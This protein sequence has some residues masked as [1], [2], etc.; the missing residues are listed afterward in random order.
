MYQKSNYKS[1]ISRCDPEKLKQLIN[2][3]PSPKTSGQDSGRI[4]GSSKDADS[5]LH[6]WINSYLVEVYQQ[7]LVDALYSTKKKSAVS[8]QVSTVQ[9]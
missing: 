2:R 8:V 9:W 6:S 1:N 5:S 3:S 7:P 4:H